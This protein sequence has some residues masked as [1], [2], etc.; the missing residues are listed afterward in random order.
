MSNVHA[1][2]RRIEYSTD[3]VFLS[4]LPLHHTFSSTCNFNAPISAGST[5]IFGRSFKP[6]DIREDIETERVTILVGV[7]LLFEHFMA[8]MQ[9]RIEDAPRRKRI[10]FRVLSGISAGIGRLTGKNVAGAV[11]KKQLAAGGLGS[12]RFCISGAAPLR[13]DVEDSFYQIGIPIVQG[14]GMTEAS[15]VISVN[16]IGK[17]KRRTV[18]PPLDGVTVEIAQPSDEGIGEI[19]VSGMNVMREYFKNHAATRD[20]LRDGKLFTGDLGKMDAKGYITIVGRKKSV[21][22][23]AGGKNV[24]PDEI[25]TL[26]GRS[27]YILECI[28]MGVDDRK[29]NTRIGA[30]VVPDYDA[31][32]ASPDLRESLT[33]EKIREII[34]GEIDGVCS[35]LADYKRIVEFQVRGQE[36]PKTTTRK[37]KRHLVKWIEE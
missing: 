26:L 13:P 37:I 23:T 12:I 31:L 6:R 1:L 34:G 11:F 15:P 2:R 18:G 9:K 33:E 7:P 3:D 27:P 20:V 21:I 25:E 14:Y 19:V 22:V 29:G 17:P 16:P 24:Y 10:L 5:I 30:I 8:T 28:V 4:L 35:E 36:F 32:G